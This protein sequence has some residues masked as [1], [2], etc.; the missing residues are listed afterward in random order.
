MTIHRKRSVEEM[1]SSSAS[2]RKKEDCSEERTQDAKVVRELKKLYYESLVDIE[3]KFYFNDLH[4]RAMLPAELSSKPT[5]LLLGQ[6]STGKTTFIRHLIGCDY[7]SMHIGPE[8]TTDK[9][10]A[11]VHGEEEK[12]IKGSALI[13]VKD[14]PF[15]GLHEFGDG[16]LNK[17]EAAIVNDEDKGNDLLKDVNIIDTPGVLSGE[18]QRTQR[19]YE[20]SKVSKWFAER[21]D[22]ILLMFDAYKLDISDEFKSVME[23]LK[24][25]EDK[26]HCVLNKADS[27]DTESLMRVYGALLWNL[28]KILSG[29]EV[30]RIYVGSFQD[31]EIAR[32]E[33]TSLFEKDR[34][35]LMKHLKDLPTLCGMRKVNEM[36]KRISLNIANICILGHLRSKMPA[37]YGGEQMKKKLIDT[38]QEQ[39]QE[40]SLKYNIDI[41]AF[42][43]AAEFG[44]KLQ[45]FD[46]YKFPKIDL[47]VLQRLRLILQNEIPRIVG[48]VAGVSDEGVDSDSLL[49]KEIAKERAEQERRAAEAS[50][51]SAQSML[52]VILGIIVFMLLAVIAIFV[53]DKDGMI[54]STFAA[55]S[56][57]IYGKISVYTRKSSQSATDSEF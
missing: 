48:Y 19:G 6:Y 12:Y 46:F 23:G 18:K 16:F 44:A 43:D 4:R 38:L 35:V 41:S 7:P 17:F 11:V 54:K 47:T 24:P 21:S 28:G 1:S 5:I 3:K 26:V 40:V 34:D 32:P 13:A 42:P 51:Q 56:N 30:T 2:G 52:I 22:L 10:V 29:A 49:D 39:Y 9:F 36:V 31:K 50:K 25:H 14:L 55:F 45:L 15:Q 20:F 8:P 53:F 37:L 57:D 33:F 27:L